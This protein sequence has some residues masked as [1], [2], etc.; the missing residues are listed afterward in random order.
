MT[1]FEISSKLMEIVAQS[2]QALITLFNELRT[3]PEIFDVQ[4]GMDCRFYGEKLI[5]EE[6]VEATLYDE[7]SVCYWLEICKRESEW[8]VEAS[9]LL[10]RHSEQEIIKEFPIKSV[11]TLDELDLA[12]KSFIELFLNESGVVSSI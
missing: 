2:N 1:E 3:N 11:K 10:N 6:F 5:L 12:L 4:R 8:E 9:I 7:T